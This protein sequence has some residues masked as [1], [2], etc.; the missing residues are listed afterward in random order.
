MMRKRGY[1]LSEI[2][3]ALTIVGVIAALVI[4]QLVKNIQKNETG[5]ILAKSVEQLETGF[6]NVI[7]T[8][9]DH[10]TD[11]SY[12]EVLAVISP[13]DLT[14]DGG[15]G[16]ESIDKSIVWASDLSKM[17]PYL[18]LTKITMA[19]SDFKDIKKFD[20]QK[21]A[22]ISALINA[23]TKYKFSKTPASVFIFLG[24]AFVDNDETVQQTDPNLK[25]GTI[26]IDTNGFDKAP[27]VWGKDLFQFKL[28]N[29]G[30]MIPVGLDDY[31]EKCADG[32][33]T[34]GKSCTARVV[35]DGWKVKYY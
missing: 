1:T 22:L 32:N 6:Q 34:D 13:D 24:T 7:Q 23:N 3:V 10:Y 17:L 8:A 11:G 27:N 21:D 19:Y 18:G 33:I 26:T 14:T 25:V 20:G 9:N 16:A 5:A 28:H 2:L 15:T 12:A 30:K 35:A 29:N 4:P 31:T